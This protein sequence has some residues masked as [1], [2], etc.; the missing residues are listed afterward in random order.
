[1]DKDLKGKYFLK[2]SEEEQYEDVA[3]MFDGVRILQVA[4]M[5][6]RGEAINVY[7]EQ[8]VD[9]SVDFVIAAQDGKIRRKNID[10]EITFV[11]SDRYATD[12]DIDPQTQY[13]AFIDYLCEKDIWVKSLYME[14][15]VRCYANEEYEP[16]SIKLRRG[17][18]RNYILGSIRMATLMK[19]AAVTESD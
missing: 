6:K 1:M 13:D 9:G 3:T 17:H 2:Q 16:T 15:E 19:P 5:N 14:K 8:W 7:N 10:I 18:G 4:G 12:P 11:V